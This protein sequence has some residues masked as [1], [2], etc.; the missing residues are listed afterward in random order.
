MKSI[1]IATRKSRLA[2][3]QSEYAGDLL[4]KLCPDVRI[5][6]LGVLTRGDRDRSDFLQ[7]SASAGFF[8]SEVEKALLRGEADLAVH[9]FKDLP[10]ALTDGLCIAAVPPRESPCDA[11]VCS[12]RASSIA[13]LPAG[14]T[15]GTSSLR[16]IAQV[17]HLRADLT[18]VPLRGNVETRVKKVSTG[19][20]EAIIVAKAGLDRLG[21]S[22]KISAIL[23]C[24][25]FLPAPAQGALALQIR[26]DNKELAQLVEKLDH[27]PSRIT[28]E[29]ERC[30]LASVQGGCSVPLGAYA[31]IENEQMTITAMICD[32]QGSNFIKRSKTVS[33][34]EA[35]AGAAQLAC[36]LLDSGGERIIA[37]IEKNR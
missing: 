19:Q 35:M 15:V 20:I 30:I 21:L 4:K 26:A 12:C 36:E 32:E 9:S 13:E 16:R 10:T 22:E 6:L 14:T 28:A 1:T 23:P 24:E 3:V 33:V 11:L 29:V 7:E 25:H 31:K 18:C 34:K 37:A 17:K 2:V 5:S 8:T 27:K